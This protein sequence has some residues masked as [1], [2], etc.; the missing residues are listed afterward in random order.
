MEISAAKIKP[1]LAYQQHAVIKTQTQQQQLQ[2]LQQQQQLNLNRPHPSPKN[3]LEQHGC[4]L[5]LFSLYF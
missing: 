5:P 1:I 4:Q 2:L 3:Q